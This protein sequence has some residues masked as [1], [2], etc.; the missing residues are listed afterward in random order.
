MERAYDVID[1]VAAFAEDVGSYISTS[2]IMLGDAK[3]H[4]DDD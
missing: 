2:F 3:F 4:S 1:S